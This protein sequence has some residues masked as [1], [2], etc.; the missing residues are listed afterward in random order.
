MT[1][2]QQTLLMQKLNNK[3]NYM[4]IREITTT[5][6]FDEVAKALG[7]SMESSDD[8]GAFN[9]V[10]I[11]SIDTEKQEFVIKLSRKGRRG[12]KSSTEIPNETTEESMANID[13]G[14]DEV[15]T[16]TEE[17]EELRNTSV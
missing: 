7:V 11:A 16:T 6:S 1:L 10:E 8:L 2:L 9:K 12:T 17:L 5:V 15:E 13:N 3:G 4:N 14:T